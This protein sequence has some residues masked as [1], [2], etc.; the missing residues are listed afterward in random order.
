M[1]AA[2][3]GLERKAVRASWEAYWPHCAG[4]MPG[5]GRQLP[6]FWQ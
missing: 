6:H 3:A 1:L 4:D 5:T 2:A